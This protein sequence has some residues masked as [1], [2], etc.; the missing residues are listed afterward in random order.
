MGMSKTTTTDD[1]GRIVIPAEFREQHGNRYRIVELRDRIELI[2][3]DEDAVAGFREA[4]GD[5]F[6]DHS[7]ADIRAFAAEAAEREA[8]DDLARADDRDP[9]DRT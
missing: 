7:L 8:L 9:G 5:A 3:L 1:R 6:A 4:V 2:P